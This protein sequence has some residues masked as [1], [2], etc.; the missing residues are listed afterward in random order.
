MKVILKERFLNL[1]TQRK[2]EILEVCRQE[3]ADNGYDKTSTNNIVAELSIAKG[4]FFKYFGSKENLYMYLIS[5]I[6]EES[7]KVQGNP[8]SYKR[9]DLFDRLDEL[10]N[11]S[12]SYCRDNPLKYRLILE[13]ELNTTSSMYKKI[14]EMKKF[15]SNDSIWAIYED[16][17]WSMYNLSREEICTVFLWFVKGVKTDLQERIQLGIPIDEYEDILQERINIYKKAIFNG[18]YKEK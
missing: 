15:Y 11:F 7:S 10:L 13:A 2:R 4:S 17:D 3:F 6:Y 1:P 9:S 16:V 5:E 14:L 18:I 12:M 8:D